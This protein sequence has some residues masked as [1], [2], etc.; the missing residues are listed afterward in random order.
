MNFELSSEQQAFADA[1]GKFALN[2]LAPGALE[3]AQSP[4]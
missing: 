1:V 2:E 3:R 4:P